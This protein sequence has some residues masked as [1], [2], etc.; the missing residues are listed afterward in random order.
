[1]A[2]QR[3]GTL[4]QSATDAEKTLWTHLRNRH[5]AGLK[6]RRQHP[7][8]PYIADFACP[9]AKL[10]VELDGGRHTEATDARRTAYLEA[11]GNTVVRFWNNEVLQNTEGVLEVLSRYLADEP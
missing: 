11:Q 5:L 9:E 3:S 6:F 4:R 7:I 10:V 8:G 2:T 1:M